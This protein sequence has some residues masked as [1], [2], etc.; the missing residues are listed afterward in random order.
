MKHRLQLIWFSNYLIECNREQMACDAS[1]CIPLSKLC[2]GVIDCDD[3]TD[4]L[5]CASKYL[6]IILILR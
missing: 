2:D 6:L 4:E 1:R 3:R 5:D